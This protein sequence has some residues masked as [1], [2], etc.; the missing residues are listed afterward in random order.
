MSG[1]AVWALACKVH[2]LS[3]ILYV[4]AISKQMLNKHNNRETERT[5]TRVFLKEGC[6]LV[7][8]GRFH[9]SSHILEDDGKDTAPKYLIK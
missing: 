3:G 1:S 8:I 7:C 2:H 4:K 5:N 6:L 9:S